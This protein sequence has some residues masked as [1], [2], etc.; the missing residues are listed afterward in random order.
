MRGFKSFGNHKVSIPLDRG[1]TAI[2]GP[3]GSGKSNIA[4][5]VKLALGELSARSLRASRFSEIIFDGGGGR[6]A[7][8][9]WVSV[10]FDNSDRKIPVD[11]DTV[12]VSREV[13][14]S[15]ESVYR[16][17]GKRISRTALVDTLAMAGISPDGYN[18]V[19]QGTV[20]RLAEVSSEE[21]RK[22]IEKLVGIEEY[23]EKK[24]QAQR[25]L[26]EA[27]VSLRIA[28]AK[29]EDVEKRILE[30]ERERNKAIRHRVLQE[31]IRSVKA[32]LISARLS[33]LE[34]RLQALRI[35]REELAQLY[36]DKERERDEMLR[37]LS[38][39][40]Q[41]FDQVVKGIEDEARELV[42][43]EKQIGEASS[44][45]AKLE[46]EASAKERELLAIRAELAKAASRDEELVKERERLEEELEKLNSRRE[47]LQTKADR[48]RKAVERINDK[49]QWLDERV[50]G[51]DEALE[52]ALSEE[53]ALADRV[54]ELRH[55]KQAITAEL[56]AVEDTTQLLEKRAAQD[57]KRLSE[58]RAELEEL[59]RQKRLSRERKEQL[60]SLIEE[61]SKKT[62]VV[63]E[64]LKSVKHLIEKARETISEYEAKRVVAE[65]AFPG[66]RLEEELEKLAKKGAIKGY[67]GR[68]GSLIRI[69]ERFRPQLEAAAREWLDA[70]LVEDWESAIE[71]LKVIK[72]RGL[73]R[74]R[75]VP[76]S[77][78]PLPPPRKR[79]GYGV[80]ASDVIECSDDVRRVVDAVFSNV[81][82][83]ESSRDAMLA[84]LEG[85]RA[86]SPS[87]EL[88]SSMFIEGGVLPPVATL[89]TLPSS[90]EV[91]QIRSLLSSLAEAA[92]KREALA[93]ELRRRVER[94]IAQKEHILSEA[95]KLEKRLNALEDQMRALEESIGESQQKLEQLRKRSEALKEELRSTEDELEHS[96][97]LLSK[98][99]EKV[100]KLRALRQPPSRSTL[101]NALSKWRAEL[102]KL[103]KELSLLDAEIKVISEVKIPNVSAKR[104]ELCARRREL[105]EAS[106]RIGAELHRVEQR[107]EEAR[108]ALS[109]LE[110]ERAEVQSKATSRREAKR[111][112]EQ[113]IRE[114][115]SELSAVES[116]LK[117]LTSDMHVLELK[118]Q[119]LEAEEEGLLSELSSLGYHEPVRDLALTTSEY[120]KILDRLEDELT[121]LGYI[122]FLAEEQYDALKQDYMSLSERINQL[123]EEKRAIIEFMKEIEAKKREVF[124]KAYRA[125]NEKFAEYFHR[126]T[127]G[128]AWLQLENEEDP[129]SG[130]VDLIAQFPG[131]S[132]R[133]ISGASGGEKSVAAVAFL[134]AM[135]SMS[136]LP[137]YIFDEI[138]AHL[139]A[140]N[141]ERLA[142]LLRELSKDSQ[143]IVITLKDAMIARADRVVGVY[144]RNGVSN[145]VTLS[146]SEVVA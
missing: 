47:L 123:E 116:E 6:R 129:F 78:V 113:R 25:E 139:D 12:T 96:Q 44:L 118:I 1:L 86:I 3:N 142:E 95:S 92:E 41:E 80:F 99:S 89:S 106:R 7:Q 134:L 33:S 125:I 141:A 119:R 8:R 83:S 137:F 146:V 81:L 132:P 117:Q 11:A 62:Q 20:M 42:E 22:I 88:F 115:R 126:I 101:L 131:K 30:L 91:D 31:E 29:V 74:A 36:R 64:T 98:L 4:D 63:E 61:L 97:S 108:A 19:M 52:K 23:D 105:E 71:C 32:K 43:L 13:D 68:L 102:S 24:A 56:S 136:P 124:L 10:Q 94:S 104:D 111:V 133:L 48:A 49:L 73:G 127:G 84:A 9:A 70:I 122:N 100:E 34:Q 110:H 103:E 72:E 28:L 2:T 57:A 93:R 45:V 46:A 53:R 16:L 121:S 114:I 90:E 58:L 138:D 59:L 76:L 15:G 55:K 143:F 60:S 135:Q 27:E 144:L 38:E 65:K 50:S 17:N 145:V 14:A 35:E 69:P 77:A 39:A 37:K 109:K 66:V 54:S 120:E 21:R 18:I 87:G 112:V 40:E 85:F 128:K 130:G 75:V 51:Y 26:E 140:R 67:V 5:A 82:V 107:L 79:V